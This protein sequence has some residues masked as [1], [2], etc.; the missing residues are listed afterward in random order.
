MTTNLPPE[1]LPELPEPD[2]EAVGHEIWGQ[3]VTS[4]VWFKE[5]VSAYG[6][7]CFKAGAAAARAEAPVA[8]LVEECKRLAGEYA[9]A[10]PADSLTYWNLM[11]AIDRLAA[12]AQ[13]PA[14]PAAEPTKPIGFREGE[15][16]LIRQHRHEAFAAAQPPA[17]PVELPPL[18]SPLGLDSI[19]PLY[20]ADQMREYARASLAKGQS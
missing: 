4:D 11:R 13:P 1:A 3:N 18:P 9:E 10:G 19:R 5:R 2:L 7:I 15:S 16:D 14:Q 6:L 8:P 20:T 17:Q 12:T